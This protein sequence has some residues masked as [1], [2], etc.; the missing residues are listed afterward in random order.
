MATQKGNAVTCRL[1]GKIGDIRIFR[2]RDG[3]TNVS[4]TPGANNKTTDAQRRRFQ[5]AVLYGRP[6]PVTPEAP[7]MYAEAAAKRGRIPIYQNNRMD[8]LIIK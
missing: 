2:Q 5:R 8:L 7:E 6:V 4:K 3:K 1:R